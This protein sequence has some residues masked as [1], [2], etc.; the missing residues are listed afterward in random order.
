M[1]LKQFLKPNLWKIV[2]ILIIL[3]LVTLIPLFPE[4]AQ[5]LM[6]RC[7]NAPIEIRCDCSLI[8][9]IAYAFV[10]STFTYC[11]ESFGVEDSTLFVYMLSVLIISYLISCGIVEFVKKVKKN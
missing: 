4:T 1:N 10:A 9:P 2:L 3:L 8:S 11:A 6:P 5:S 7:C